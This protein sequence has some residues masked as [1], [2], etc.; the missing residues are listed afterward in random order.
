MRIAVLALGR[1]GAP[2]RYAF[3]MAVALAAYADVLAVVAAGAEN[4]D[5]WRAAAASDLRLTIVVHETYES[6]CQFLVH[7]SQWWRYDRIANDIR[8]FGPDV[9]YSPF[10]HYWEKPV[11]ARLKGISSVGT[12]HDPVL[13]RGEDSR[14]ERWIDHVLKKRDFDRY[15]ILTEAF[16][17]FL[18]DRGVCDSDIVTIPHA[19]F[20]APPGVTPY[21]KPL[22]NKILFF[23]RVISYK[24]LD[25]LLAAMPAVHDRLPH[26]RL[27]I[28]G[29]GDYTPYMQAIDA[30]RDYIDL[31]DGWVAPADVERYF[32]GSDMVVLPYVEASQSGIIPLGQSLGCPAV[33]SAVGGLPGQIDHGRT[34]L[35]VPPGDAGALAG[36]I[37]SAYS[38]PGLLNEMSRECLRFSES[39]TWDRSARA[40]IDFLQ[41]K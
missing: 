11:Y 27:V 39:N 15:V 14:A 25:V 34:G 21:G 7:S 3:M 28:A 17:K 2:P 19:A 33:A 4:L 29:E 32:T 5:E 37:V 30:Q 23:G 38:N 41:K 10:C 12:V 20:A 18:T 22:K 9:V 13:H 24:G 35:L 36:A 16:R 40:L 1:R 26:L 31:Y 6:R 8:C